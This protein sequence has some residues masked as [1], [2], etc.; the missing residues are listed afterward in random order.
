MSESEGGRRPP[1]IRAEVP[2]PNLSD[3]VQIDG[4]WAQVGP[5]Q[6]R[7]RFLDDPKGESTIV[8]WTNYKFQKFYMADKSSI[9]GGSV[10]GLLDRG[11]MDEKEYWSI[12]TAAKE[13]NP[14]YRAE[15]NIFGI[16]TTIH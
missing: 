1:E 3:I 10:R 15:M 12:I 11:M 9:S 7:V 8:D 5:V 6:D 16:Y 13:E 14:H 4:R 2:K